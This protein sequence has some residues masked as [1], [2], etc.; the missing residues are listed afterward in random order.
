MPELGASFSAANI[1]GGLIF[2]A[3]GFVAFVY[4]KK[5]ARFAPMGI[6]IALMGFPYFV[7]NTVAMFA[8]GVILTAAL[9]I[10]KDL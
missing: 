2:G 10:L 9:F 5:M 3:I 4:G 6:G 8:V 1:I 7:S